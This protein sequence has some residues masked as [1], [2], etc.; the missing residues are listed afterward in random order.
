M[1]ETN[2]QDD[3]KVC[4]EISERFHL[5]I[6]QHDGVPLARCKHA[7]TLL[8]FSFRELDYYFSCR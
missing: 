4:Q 5:E 6:S 2:C 1:T 3:V 7:I 8:I